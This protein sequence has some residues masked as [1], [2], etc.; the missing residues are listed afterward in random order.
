MNFE[1]FKTEL[2]RIM[3]F[4]DSFDEEL[5]HDWYI[6]FKESVYLDE[7]EFARFWFADVSFE[8]HNYQLIKSTR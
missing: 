6:A 5:F 2:K 4:E 3:D 1:I 7:K 8:T